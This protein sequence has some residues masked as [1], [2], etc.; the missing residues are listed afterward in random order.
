MNLAY[1]LL[2]H[3]AEENNNN[4]YFSP[5]VTMI[6]FIVVFWEHCKIW[7]CFSTVR[8]I[9]FSLRWITR[10]NF[11][12]DSLPLKRAGHPWTSPLSLVSA[13]R[14]WSSGDPLCSL[15]RS[16]CGIQGCENS[17]KAGYLG[18]V[19]KLT[20]SG[21]RNTSLFPALTSPIRREPLRA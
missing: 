10:N 6:N 12:Q 18:E 16:A 5:Y 7:K 21:L 9:T 2:L 4:K 20:V 11:C 8:K 1:A 14:L 3:G 17:Y 19:A 13:P 15:Y